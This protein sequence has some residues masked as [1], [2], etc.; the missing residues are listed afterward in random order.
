MPSLRRTL[1]SKAAGSEAVDQIV[2]SM[3]QGTRSGGSERRARS[4]RSRC[5]LR[6][7]R[8]M[9][10]QWRRYP[11]SVDGELTQVA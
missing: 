11:F 8:L 6:A 10:C 2:Q 1:G 3:A 5:S 4:A 7:T 9:Q